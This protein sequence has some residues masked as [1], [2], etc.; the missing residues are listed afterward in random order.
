MFYWVGRNQN[1]PFAPSWVSGDTNSDIEGVSAINGA[2]VF[3]AP[4]NCA[5]DYTA[6]VQWADGTS[7]TALLGGRGPRTLGAFGPHAYAE[8]GTDFTLT[9]VSDNW[10]ATKFGASTITGHDKYKFT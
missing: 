3:S 5:C 10:G 2:G 7:S 9:N 4:S 1:D 6:S 8:E